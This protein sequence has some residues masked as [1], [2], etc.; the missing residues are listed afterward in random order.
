MTFIA[1]PIKTRHAPHGEWPSRSHNFA[2]DG[3]IDASGRVRLPDQSKKVSKDVQPN[4]IGRAN[5][6]SGKGVG[7]LTDNQCRC[8]ITVSRFQGGTTTLV[9][10]VVWIAIVA[11]GMWLLWQYEHAPGAMD[12]SPPQWPR[13]SRISPASDKPTLLFFAHPKCPCT[14]ASIGELE[15]IMA[16]CRD[17]VD[18]YA[19]FVRPS[20]NEFADWEQTDL[21]RSAAQI[22]GVTA[23]SDAGGIEAKLFRAVTSGFVVLY[24]R[25]GQLQFQGG[26][27]SS[28]GHRGE[29]AGRASIF[30]VL[31]EGAAI[32]NETKVYGCRLGTSSQQPSQACCQD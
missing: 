16:D 20:G 13:E 27:T 8:W 7:V 10:V 3:R 5:N 32:V 9:F 25:H 23:V 28:R 4:R 15:Q 14:R 12:P 22:P 26:I 1:S 17:Q 18:T 11:S 30:A 24:D 21:R 2:P 31:N 6:W 19:M 29:N